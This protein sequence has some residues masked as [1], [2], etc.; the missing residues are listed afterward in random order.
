MLTA[1]LDLSVLATH[2]NTRGIGRYVFDLTR[3]LG[4]IAQQRGDIRLLGVEQ[5]SMQGAPRITE[6]VVGAA[7]RLVSAE[8]R[9][10]HASWAYRVRFR[11][12]AATALVSAD[13]LHSGHPNATPLGKLECP[14]IGTCHDLI[15][16]LY[17]KHH[18]DWR[19]GFGEGRRR[20]DARRFLGMRHV[21]AIS[22]STAGDLMKLLG[23]PSERITVV[24]NGVDTER[25]RPEPAEEDEA[26]L[27]RLNVREPFVMCVGAA[28]WRKNCEGM[29]AG[30]AHARRTAKD[31]RLLWVGRLG[32]QDAQRVD[33]AAERQGVAQF[34]GRSGF[35]DDAALA[36]LYRRAVAQ[37]FVS[38]A[39]GFGYPVVEAMAAGCP[40][41]TSDRSS[42]S[43]I[44]AGA[45]VTVDPEDVALIGDALAR[46]AGSEACRDEL[47]GLGMERARR[48]TLARMASETLEVYREVARSGA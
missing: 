15:P 18:T 6:D 27:R 23:V 22:R 7:A 30:F 42:L 44:G 43:E 39:E 21:I 40:V 12:A 41:V 37:M 19:D 29:I 33:R 9:L 5:L 38:R 45:A 46:L 34:V 2:T 8:R 14:R 35:V 48:F 11:M 25:F 17:P 10:G 26:V 16:L 20:L 32:A 47:R 4:V 31:L 28:N 36:A 1:L 3:G 13:V 24:Y